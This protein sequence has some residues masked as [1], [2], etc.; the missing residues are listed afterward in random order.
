MIKF[1]RTNQY[2]LRLRV[3]TKVYLP[4]SLQREHIQSDAKSLLQ[5]VFYRLYLDDQKLLLSPKRPRRSL[6]DNGNEEIG[7]FGVGDNEYG[8]VGAGVRQC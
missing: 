4:S 3:Q 8:Q 7:R 5:I 1:I 2:F 6:A